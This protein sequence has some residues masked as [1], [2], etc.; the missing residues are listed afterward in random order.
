MPHSMANAT[1]PGPGVDFQWN[2][3][4]SALRGP[5]TSPHG[6]GCRI[7]SPTDDPSTPCILHAGARPTIAACLP[8]L[9]E[10]QAARLSAAYNGRRRPQRTRTRRLGLG[11]DSRLLGPQRRVRVRLPGIR[12]SACSLPLTRLQWRVIARPLLPT[13]APGAPPVTPR[14]SS[15]QASSSSRP[16][17]RGRAA[18][19]GQRSPAGTG[20][21]D[22]EPA[23]T[24]RPQ[25][26]A[27]DRAGLGP[28][29]VPEGCRPGWPHRMRAGGAALGKG[30]RP[31]YPGLCPSRRKGGDAL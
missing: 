11:D 5:G 17:R 23:R 7:P 30:L 14:A 22:V 18:G 19:Q 9:C 20:S 21:G 31:P 16:G 8:D 10:S 3:P 15:S 13:L 4:Y 29:V 28:R 25:L 26:R 6:P 1:G 12:L 24:P 2:T 27:E